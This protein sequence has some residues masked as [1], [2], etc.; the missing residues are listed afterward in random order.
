MAIFQLQ[1]R[2]RDR[3]AGLPDK[4]RWPTLPWKRIQGNHT[5]NNRRVR[6][7]AWFEWDNQA[8]GVGIPVDSI[9][10]VGAIAQ[11]DAGEG[12]FGHVA[13]VESV[14]ADGTIT[15]TESS[16]LE[17]STSAWNF[18]WR[19][20]TVSPSW[21]QRFIHVSAG[22]SS[23]PSAPV[24]S[25]ATGVT[26]NGFTANWGTAAGATSYRLDVSTS[27]TFGS[28]VTGF[29]D[30]D[31]GS[32]LNRNVTGSTLASSAVTFQWTGGVG[33][34]Q[35][36]LFVGS[37]PGAWNLADQ[38]RGMQLS[39]GVSGLPTNGSTVYVRL[40]SLIL[41]VWQ[42]NDYAITAQ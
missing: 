26:A 42:Y 32:V 12:G 15:I 6:A 21:F 18:R 34:T 17:V 28:F 13:I 40:W 7:Q 35:Y 37:T 2:V 14:N 38:N 3:S 31:V 22:G 9:P 41:G 29:Q 27:R 20:R 10:T 5:C 39:A 4:N 23:S 1:T 16:F 25:S 24:A 36:W 30:L 11:T 8:L 33:V 19:H